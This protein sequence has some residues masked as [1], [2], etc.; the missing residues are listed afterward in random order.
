MQPRMAW[1]W[2]LPRLSFRTSLAPIRAAQQ[3]VT[4]EWNVGG[5]HNSS[6]RIF[7]HPYLGVVVQS[8]C[9]WWRGGGV[10]EAQ[11]PDVVGPIRAALRF[12]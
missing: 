4:I 11:L 1:R 7:V 8:S 6:V 5:S 2:R 9:K 10:P 12:V 3:R